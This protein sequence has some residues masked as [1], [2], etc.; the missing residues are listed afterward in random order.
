[1]STTWKKKF[2]LRVSD[3]FKLNT[4]SFSVILLMIRN[5]TDFWFYIVII[6]ACADPM[7]QSH[8]ET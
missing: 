3:D 7:V 8:I 1:M 2:E 4:V 5:E 6:N